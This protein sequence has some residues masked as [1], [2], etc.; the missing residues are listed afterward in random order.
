MKWFLSWLL[1]VA[2]FEYLFR[3]QD[4]EVEEALL[5]GIEK[6]KRDKALAMSRSLLRSGMSVEDVSEHSGLFVE[7]VREL[8]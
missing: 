7:E 4:K 3:K 8:V 5:D 2:A 1:G 6:G